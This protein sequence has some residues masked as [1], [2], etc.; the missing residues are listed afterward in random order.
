MSTMEQIGR[1]RQKISFSD[2]LY[3]MRIACT[4]Q[5]SPI[6]RGSLESSTVRHT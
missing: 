2:E 1:G 3:Y 5:A 6:M 4:I